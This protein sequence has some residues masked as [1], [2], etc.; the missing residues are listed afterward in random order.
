MKF[1][2]LSFGGLNYKFVLDTGVSGVVINKSVLS[3]LLSN[4]IITKENYT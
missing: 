2:K 3:D 4:G 1:I